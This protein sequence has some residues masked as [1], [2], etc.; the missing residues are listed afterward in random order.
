MRGLAKQWAVW[1]SRHITIIRPR[2]EAGDEMGSVRFPFHRPRDPVPQGIEVHEEELALI[3]AQLMYRMRCECGRSWFDLRLP[4][5]AECP[6][7]A[8]KGMVLV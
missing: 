3:K 5:L 1:E 6:S 8:K 7:C 2:N 4:K